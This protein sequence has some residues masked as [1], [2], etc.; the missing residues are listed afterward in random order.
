MNLAKAQSDVKSA[1]ADFR[2]SEIEKAIC[3]EKLEANLS[4]VG[5]IRQK[6]L[7]QNQLLVDI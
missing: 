1:R 2:Q 3:E 7:K 4:Q 6:T 5:Q